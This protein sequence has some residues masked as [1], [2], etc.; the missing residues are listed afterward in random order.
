MGEWMWCQKPQLV[1]DNRCGAIGWIEIPKRSAVGQT[2]EGNIVKELDNRLC[3]VIKILD[4]YFTLCKAMDSYLRINYYYW[5][6][7]VR[8]HSS[9]SKWKENH[10]LCGFNETVEVS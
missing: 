2:F 9:E 4:E 5:S 7:N 3:V 8:I 6:L 10:I 1:F